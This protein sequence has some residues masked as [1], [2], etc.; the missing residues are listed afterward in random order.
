METIAT[1]ALEISESDLVAAGTRRRVYRHPQTADKV[2]KIFWDDQV[3]AARRARRRGRWFKS[4]ARFDDNENDYRQFRRVERHFGTAIRC[5]YRI[6]GY[7]E[8]TLGR[9]LVTEHVRNADGT[10]SDTLAEH[11]RK[12]GAGRVLPALEELFDELARY[13]VVAKDPHV[14][15]VLVRECGG[16]RLELVVIDG[17][18]DNN[19]IP[20][21][22]LSRRL[23]NRKLMRK[24]RSLLRH[25]W[26]I[27]RETRLEAPSTDIPESHRPLQREMAG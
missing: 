7:V 19:V 1:G 8:T 12:C 9:G 13:H 15:N 21:A 3:P 18:G 27:N 5:I 23:N 22:T 6:Y 4:L 25:I 2:I 14:E 16:G 24:K 20:F 17:L 11:V 26:R 10:T